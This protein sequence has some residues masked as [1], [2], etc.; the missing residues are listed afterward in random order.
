MVR[1]NLSQSEN[2]CLYGFYTSF[3]LNFQK[4]KG[5]FQKM[6]GKSLFFGGMPFLFFK[7]IFFISGGNPDFRYLPRKWWEWKYPRPLRI[8]FNGGSVE[9]TVFALTVKL[10][11]LSKNPS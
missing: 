7:S 11:D 3:S 10:L 5:N 9:N 8:I 4:M 6:K 1:E 2:S